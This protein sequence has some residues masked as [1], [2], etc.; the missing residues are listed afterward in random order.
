MS[1]LRIEKERRKKKYSSQIW[2]D[3]LIKE[4]YNI[5]KYQ[6]YHYNKF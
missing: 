6:N 3:S 5:L 1:F 4:L 2:E